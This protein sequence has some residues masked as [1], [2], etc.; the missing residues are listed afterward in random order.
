MA[1]KESH[2]EQGQGWVIDHNPLLSDLTSMGVGGTAIA[3]VKLRSKEA[4]SAL[5]NLLQKLG[6]D[7]R[8][9]GRGT[10][11]LAKD[12]QLPLVL[13]SYAEREITPCKHDGELTLIKAEAGIPLPLF[14]KNLAELELTGLEGLSG[15]PGSLGGALRMNAGSFGI[16]IA[17]VLEEIE[18]FSSHGL[19]TIKSKDLKAE[20]RSFKIKE[21]EDFIIKSAGFKLKLGQKD[22]I[23]SAIKENLLKKKASQPVGSRSAGCIFKNPKNDFAGRLIEEVGLKGKKIGGMAFSDLHANF[24]VNQ[25]QGTASEALELIKLAQDKVHNATGILLECEVE[26]W[27]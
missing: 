20:Y 12:G 18:I 24:I 13:V 8:P 3:H 23:K 6:G 26:V 25:G 11:I 19:E 27:P 15:I 17:S 21:R 22:K 7:P 2:S 5:P 1:K 16:E 14:L 10:N 4:F 9:I